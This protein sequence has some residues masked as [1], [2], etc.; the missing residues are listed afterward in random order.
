MRQNFDEL[1]YIKELIKEDE[2]LSETKLLITKKGEVIGIYYDNYIYDGVQ[3]VYRFLNDYGASVVLNPYTDSG[4]EGKWEL[5]V[6]NYHGAE[7][8]FQFELDF[9]TPIA[10]DIIEML[11]LEEVARILTE[12]EEFKGEYQMK[13]D[14]KMGKYLIKNVPYMIVLKE[15]YQV[16]ICLVLESEMADIISFMDENELTTF[17]F[18]NWSKKNGSANKK[19]D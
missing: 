15:E 12:I 19:R 13:K 16:E 3:R 11:E 18:E 17:D 10:N 1:E 9:S 6:V 14:V 7:S 2:V 5:A 8:I 4:K